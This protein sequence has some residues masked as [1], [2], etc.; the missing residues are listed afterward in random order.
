MTGGRDPPPLV[1]FDRAQPGVPLLVTGLSAAAILSADGS[2]R[3]PR[4]TRG[5]LIDWG[6]V[7]SQG[8]R[9][10]GPWDLGIEVEGSPADLSASLRS[11]LAWRWAVRTRHLL[12]SGLEVEQ[13]IVPL[14]EAPG[15]GRR[16][17]L[18]HTGTSPVSVV[19]RSEV[20]PFLA[21]VL[22]EGLKPYEFEVDA[23]ASG[24]HC[25]SGAHVLGLASAPG[26][27]ARTLDGTEWSGE[28]RVGEIGRIGA[29]YELALTP[30]AAARIDEVA[31]GGVASAVPGG[32]GYGGIAVAA[33][34]AWEA[35]GRRSWSTWLAGTPSLSFPS[36]PL[37]EQ[38]YDL[39]RGALRALYTHPDPEITGLVAGYPWYCA[40]WGRDLAW[41]L[42]AVLWMGD[43]DWAQESLRTIFRYQ[44]T[45]S[46]PLL[47][48]E[49]GELP[50]Q[51][52]P[53]PV[54]LFGTSDTTLYYPEVLRRF[55]GHTGRGELV[56]ELW[57]HLGEV[58]RWIDGKVDP[59][60]GLFT[61]GGEVLALRDAAEGVGSVHYG[62]DAPDT[63]IWDSADR[64]DHAVELQVLV[65][66][67]RRAL[68]DLA[69]LGPAR[70]PWPASRVDP[71]RIAEAVR[72][73]YAWP[74][75]RYLFDSLARNGTPARRLRPNALRAVSAGLV[76][77][78]VGR[79]MVDRALQPDLATSWGLRTLSDRDP[80]YDPQAYHGGQVWTI[81][82]AWAADAAFAIGDPDRGVALLRTI[83]ARLVEENGLANECYRGD[84]P[85]PFD[86]C[87]LLGFSVAPFLGVLFERLWGL[88][89]DASDGRLRVA[90][91]FPAGWATAS[92]RGVRIGAG[93]V[94]LTWTPGSLQVHWDGP[95]PLAV[96][97]G[98]ARV[99]VEAGGSAIV[100]LGR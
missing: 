98:T 79:A 57:P 31:W 84:R 54:F 52:S 67:A 87:F 77:P 18:R 5:G 85:E 19:V 68:A 50:M 13:T 99:R 88:T 3:C 89:P 4:E 11:L 41:M 58:V 23:G 51:L 30:G 62:I 72:T 69:A 45:R 37:L 15:V 91:K 100:P 43:A 12:A 92:V 94:D 61:N 70:E 27:S 93:R 22:V 35:A 80:S 47:A 20:P 32:A 33:A 21:P 10:T 97:A 38:A 73:R 60:D 40:L 76:D 95:A 6:G 34:D 64:R 9:L 17:R 78:D 16:L 82:T 46:I 65:H 14:S 28:R 71:A 8:V 59:I 83:A 90:P 48:A 81:A 7:Y 53:G 49:S 44:A 42:P 86:S 74:E 24:V 25:K 75:E 96:E 39:A 55:V 56:G 66:D 26:P 63:T 2:L 1:R 29:R 36:D